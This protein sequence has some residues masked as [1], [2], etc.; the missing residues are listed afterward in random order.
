MNSPST[1]PTGQDNGH[2]SSQ[3]SKAGPEPGTPV[4]DAVASALRQGAEHARKAAEEALPKLKSAASDAAYWT[5][6]GVT[7]AAVFQWTLIKTL[8]PE[9]VKNGCLDGVK[10][11]KDA[12]AKWVEQ[13]RQRQQPAPP[14]LLSAP[15]VAS[16]GTQPGT[17]SGTA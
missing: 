15:P 14:P 2:T 16:E 7:F 13:L 9:I 11:G 6:Y 5:A 8:A 12:A 1:E 3:E 10:A 4:F 17:A